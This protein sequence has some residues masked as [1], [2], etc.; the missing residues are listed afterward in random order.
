[1]KVELDSQEHGTCFLMMSNR[2]YLNLEGDVDEII[3]GYAFAKSKNIFFDSLQEN[4]HYHLIFNGKRI[5]LHVT[6]DDFI[7]LDIS[8]AKKIDADLIIL[9]HIEKNVVDF[10]GYA[11]V[12]DIYTMENMKLDGDQKVVKIN[13]NELIKF[14]EDVG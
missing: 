9:T 3:A 6:A 1:M 4:F 12:D 5:R 10:V 13:S 11:K 8:K 7:E 2:L 14:K